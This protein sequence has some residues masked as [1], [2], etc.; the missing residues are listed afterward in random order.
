[1]VVAKESDVTER[2][3]HTGGEQIQ[4][5]ETSNFGDWG[6]RIGEKNGGGVGKLDSTSSLRF[7]KDPR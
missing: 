3:I 4:G 7:D 2:M 1:M 6:L 5:N